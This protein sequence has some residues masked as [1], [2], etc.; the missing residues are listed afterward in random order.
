MIA[1]TALPR[2]TGRKSRHETV[3]YTPVLTIFS[4]LKDVRMLSVLVR[5]PASMAPIPCPPRNQ[6]SGSS[7]CPL[8]KPLLDRPRGM[9]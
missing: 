5:Q 8:T 2:P 3:A 4:P 7:L 9:G 1:W 6:E